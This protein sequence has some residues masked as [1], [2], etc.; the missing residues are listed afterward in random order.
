MASLPRRLWNAVTEKKSAIVLTALFEPTR[1]GIHKAYAPQFLYRPPFGFPRAANL[2]YYR[3]LATTPYVQMCIETILDE[4]ASLEWDIIIKPGKEDKY[5]NSDGE[6]NEVKQAEIEHLR[7]F[8][9]NPNGGGSTQSGSRMNFGESFEDVFIRKPV[10]DM[11]EVGNGILVKVFNLKEELVEIVAKDAVAFNKNP[12]RFGTYDDRDEIIIAKQI[13]DSVERVNDPLIQ[14]PKLAVSQRAAYFQYGWKTA[15]QPIPFGKREVIWLDKEPRTDDYYSQGPVQILHETLQ[16]LV[17][18]VKSD[19]DY[20]NNNNTPR[21]IIGVEGADS[22]ELKAR[23]DQLKYGGVEK[24]EFDEWRRNLHKTIFVNYVPKAVRLELTPAEL[25]EAEKQKWYSKMVWASFGVTA[26]QLGYTEDAKGQANQIVQSKVFR[27]KAINPIL[28][29]LER[30][31]T[32]DI[33][34]E[35][36]YED[37]EFIFKTFDVDEEKNKRELHKIEIETGLK[38]INE[39]R[40]EEGL[41]PVDWGDEPPRKF[42]GS[43]GGLNFGRDY[44]DMQ[45]EAMKPDEGRKLP[46]SRSPEESMRE[47]KG[48]YTIE[49]KPFG[50]YKNFDDCVRKNKDKRNPEAYCAQTHKEATGKWPS[51]K[52]VLTTNSP[53]TL[54]PGEEISDAKLKKAIIHILDI[55]K[56]KINEL[57][58]AEMKTN[59]LSSVQGVREVA[60]KVKSVLNFEGLA[61]IVRA[62]I[63]KYFLDGWDEG[64]KKIDQNFIPDQDA[65][66][67]L[68]DY[69]FEN[70]KGMTEE[71][72]ED[73]RQELKRAYMAGEGIPEIKKRVEKVF[74]A[75][76]NR[77]EMIART[78][79]SRASNFGTLGALKAGDAEGK[80]VWVSAHDDRTS[81][82]CKRLDGQEVGLYEDFKDPKG[83]W[84]GPAPPAHVNCRSTFAF[85]PD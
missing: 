24:D 38:T 74:D 68:S 42:S 54:K 49:G 84:S 15:S 85:V 10:R 66:N 53:L 59:L 27:Q 51:E 9:N 35:F 1:Q 5:L 36:N 41:D 52:K 31:Y 60:E 77:A 79:T 20:Y 48:N 65:I 21:T 63:K 44:Q 50:P 34:A 22:D 6:I 39:I 32:K 14:I 29:L 72:A 69:T 56:K 25:Q 61:E 4:I 57:I 3:Y 37:L 40:Q 19:L 33:V 17:Y 46:E 12:D 67:Y 18:S 7:T 2:T 47:K 58:E 70:V 75:G 64:E 23:A 78:E 71:I 81:A 73:L 82:L 13:I 43:F 55:N 30:R 8:F 11:L 28:R 16:Q 26:T 45:E 62:V 80:K 76:E 83:E